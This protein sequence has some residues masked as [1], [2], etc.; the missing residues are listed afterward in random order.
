MPSENFVSIHGLKRT[1]QARERRTLERN[2][3]PSYRTTKLKCSEQGGQ[4]LQVAG[5]WASTNPRGAVP[6][7]LIIRNG[8]DVMAMRAIRCNFHY[9]RLTE[10]WLRPQPDVFGWKGRKIFGLYDIPHSTYN[11]WAARPTKCLKNVS[12]IAFC[13]KPNWEWTLSSSH[14]TSPYTT[15]M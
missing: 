14:K 3:P 4:H 9:P 6:P 10:H 12:L 15:L 5:H 2:L 8:G 11:S 1:R 7:P 13:L